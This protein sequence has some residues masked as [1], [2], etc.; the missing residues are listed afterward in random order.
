MIRRC[1]WMRYEREMEEGGAAGGPEILAVA[2]PRRCSCTC[3]RR[4]LVS[5][6]PGPVGP[7]L[8][9][10]GIHRLASILDIGLV[11]IAS[12]FTLSPSHQIFEHMYGVL[13][14]DKKITNYIV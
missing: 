12:F 8:R 6:Y 11:Y 3:E 4:P 2:Q 10:R 1:R 13:N 7:S 9:A 14:V 5:L